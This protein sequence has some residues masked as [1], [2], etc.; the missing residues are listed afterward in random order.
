MPA[1][2]SLGVTSRPPAGG[3]EKLP[4][5]KPNWKR[6]DSARALHQTLFAI[7]GI[8]SIGTAFAI[9]NRSFLTAH[10]VIPDDNAPALRRYVDGASVAGMPSV[11]G[12]PEFLR[13]PDGRA[14]LAGVK[15]PDHG[16]DAFFLE[17]AAA[18]AD[19]KGKKLAIAGYP[20]SPDHGV[21]HNTAM[22]DKQGVVSEEPDP[23]Y[24]VYWNAS[25]AAGS[26]GSPI[27]LLDGSTIGPKV[28]GIHLLGLSETV[29]GKPIS[30]NQ[31]LFFTEDDI[32]R[33]E[34]WRA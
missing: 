8:N 9:G 10:H 12:T 7:T 22:I 14:E 29:G 27:F 34:Q 5:G 19:L 1:L 6:L 21:T 13:D 33:I 26:S 20:Y 30:R 3:T 24:A 25:V 28:I 23:P 11:S 31:G 17:V 4:D 18:P 32:K 2:D 16:N 15:Y